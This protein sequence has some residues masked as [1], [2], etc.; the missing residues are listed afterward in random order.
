M[1]P[2]EE[3]IN[4]ES[5]EDIEQQEL[6]PEQME[7]ES[8]QLTKQAD[9]ETEETVAD[10]DDIQNDPVSTIEEK[11]EAAIL[12]RQAGLTRRDFLQK[13]ALLAGAVMTMTPSLGQAEESNI[14]KK[15]FNPGVNYDSDETREQLSHLEKFYPDELKN[16]E[17]SIIIQSMD[18]VLKMLGP[19]AQA[20]LER[21]LRVTGGV[22]L[23]GKSINEKTRQK[24]GIP[25]DAVL[26][27]FNTKKDFSPGTQMRIAVHESRHAAHYS[28]Q[29]EKNP[30][31][32][33]GYMKYPELS[34]ET[35]EALEELKTNSETLDYLLSQLE[36][37]EQSDLTE[38]EFSSLA[39]MIRNEKI[40]M[41]D[42]Y[43]SYYSS[44]YG[45][46]HDKPCGE[47][48]VDDEVDQIVEGYFIKYNLKEILGVF[49][50]EK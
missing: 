33:V 27:M 20:D 17:R 1:K 8:R 32:E 2:L 38:E 29:L 16:S 28:D 44:R 5:K 9:K 14:E 43:W 15:R 6:S 49:E 7:G 45:A 26:I 40:Y 13:A 31:D 30:K 48:E 46:D 10:A 25:E 22:T 12:A 24:F 19:A 23:L 37:G 21:S 18:D 39:S 35:N 42:N 50:Y 11:Q 41:R 47:Y 3:T 34:K 36:M 4:E